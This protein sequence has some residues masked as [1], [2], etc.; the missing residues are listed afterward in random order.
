MDQKANVKVFERDVAEHGGYAYTTDA[1]FSSKVA[2]ERLTRIVL[3]N[4]RP[5]DIN[6]I[7]VGCG[8]GTSTN[9]YIA[10]RTDMKLSALD[11]AA[12]A[13]E[14]AKV[15]YPHIE[16]SVGD[17]VNAATLPDKTFDLVVLKGVLH[18]V[19]DPAQAI[20][21]AAKLSPRMLIIEPNGYNP[22][23]KIIEKRSA[24]HVEHEEQSFPRATIEQWCRDAGLT[25][26]YHDFAGFV[27]YFFPTIPARI[28]HFLTPLLERL[29]IVNR[30]FSAVSVIVTQGRSAGTASPT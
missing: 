12:L 22:I 23:L 8:D 13:V 27:P 17:I 7:D 18:H 29:P 4:M 26:A 15:L 21:N 10:G 5:T 11:P 30:Y 9:K 20:R 6:V 3:D 25:V 28:I 19:S 2:D 14:R 24:Y 1:S 16:F